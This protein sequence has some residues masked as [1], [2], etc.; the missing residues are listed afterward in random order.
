MPVQRTSVS[1][2]RPATPVRL[3][4]G[5]KGM[6]I[7]G[8]KETDVVNGSIIRVKAG[9]SKD[10]GLKL[11]SMPAE[12]RNAA[13]GDK[14]AKRAAEV[15]LFLSGKA[16]RDLTFTASF[17]GLEV[18]AKV[19]KGADARGL[20]KALRAVMPKGY[21]VTV[22]EKGPASKGDML[23]VVRLQKNDPMAALNELGQ[24]FNK[25]GETS[26][27]KLRKA[28]ATVAQDGMTRNEKDAIRFYVDPVAM[29]ARR[30]VD[31]AMAL[32]LADLQR[33]FHI[34]K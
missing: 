18:A 24:A 34:W 3:S 30:N 22:S 20:A 26:A 10:A 13:E 12:L 33:K 29:K 21:A 14:E 2:T 28:V 23:G 15:F 8:P 32:E 5:L 16:T 25:K 7:T 17:D 27:A 6:W 19:A 9:L 31:T 4:A 11:G 1:S